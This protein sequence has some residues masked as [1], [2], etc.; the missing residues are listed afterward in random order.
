M[1]MRRKLVIKKMKT[2]E[3]KNKVNMLRKEADLCIHQRF[4]TK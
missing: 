2:Q 4:R 1:E 3:E